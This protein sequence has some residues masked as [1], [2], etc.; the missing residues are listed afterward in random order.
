MEKGNAVRKTPEEVCKR[1]AGSDKRGG[2]A[3]GGTLRL[4]QRS[5]LTTKFP[6]QLAGTGG[7]TEV[8]GTC[9]HYYTAESAAGD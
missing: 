8:G 4:T 2:R 5:A 6:S 1:E 7:G 3:G 9:E